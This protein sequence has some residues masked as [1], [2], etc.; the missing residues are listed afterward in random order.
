MAARLKARASAIPS[1]NPSPSSSLLVSAAPSSWSSKLL[2][3][4]SKKLEGIETGLPTPRPTLL[5]LLLLS[6][7]LS[8]PASK[9]GG[10]EKGERRC[11]EGVEALGWAGR[12][13]GGGGGR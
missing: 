3:Q 10:G 7:S 1:M 11:I 5:L 4:S 2:V 9:T 6:L 8:L 12:G 13:C